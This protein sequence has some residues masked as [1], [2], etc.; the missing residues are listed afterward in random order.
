MN[1]NLLK[2]YTIFI[3][4]KNYL[5]KIMITKHDIYTDQINN[6]VKWLYYY[7]FLN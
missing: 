1:I 3:F 6:M 5:D 7:L 2:M 4:F